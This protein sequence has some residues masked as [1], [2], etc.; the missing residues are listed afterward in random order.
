MAADLVQ[1]DYDHLGQVATR[2]QKLY[3]QQSQME[4]MLRQTYQ[5]LRSSWQGDAAVAFFGEM[6]ATIFP[7]LKRLQTTLT[8][9]SAVT[10]Q[11]SQTFRQAEEEAAKG[12]NFDGGG[13][14]EE[15]AGGAGGGS[16]ANPTPE[17]GGLG[18]VFGQVQN[19]LD[20]AFG[21]NNSG[22]ADVKDRI[23]DA[24]GGMGYD[25]EAIKDIIANATPEQLKEIWSDSALM[26]QLHQELGTDNY[27][28]LVVSVGMNHSGTVAHTS[29]PDADTAIRDHL[30]PYVT[31]AVADNRQ[32]T[33]K[34]AVVD[35]A[36]WDIA[37]I[38]RYGKAVW[39]SGKRDSINGF[40][41]TEGRVWIHEDKGN[42]GTMIHEGMHKYSDAAMIG[43]S[44]PLNEGVTE[45]FTR[46]TTDNLGLTGRANYQEN[47]EFVSSLSS[48]VG[49]D[50]VADAYFNGNM[51]GL[52]DAYV[53]AGYTEAQWDTMIE[54]TEKNEWADAELLT[55]PIPAPGAP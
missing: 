25:A 32:I 16:G 22:S 33:G 50:V 19:A 31:E 11:I 43:V 53:N 39:E 3:D 5:Q 4:S 54:H 49:E 37:G 8:T 18:A 23:R 40:V 29:A 41:D 26:E 1:S 42:S 13:T 24:I 55:T 30:G 44:Q 38:N 46:S 47:Y 9:A 27:L 36:N 34:V 52:K 51:D 15:N 12:I 35:D 45:Y 28:N 7:T 2:F 17:I 20:A 6:D 21:T 48:L 14:Q 10:S